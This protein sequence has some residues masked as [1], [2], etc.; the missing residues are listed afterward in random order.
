M[1]LFHYRKSKIWWFDF[2]FSGRRIRES[3]KT[4]NT[5]LARDAERAKRRELEEEYNGVPKRQAPKSLATAAEEY[6]ELKKA[7]V[8]PNTSLIMTQ[9]F[10]LHLLPKLGKKL[11]TEIEPGTWNAYTEYRLGQGAAAA[12]VNHELGLVRGILRRHRL[13]EAIRQ[14]VR[15]LPV[16][17]AHGY[18]LT[19]DEESLLLQKCL[20]STFPYI[21]PIVVMALSTGMRREEIQLL[22]WSNLNFDRKTV[23]VGKSKT[24]NGTGRVIHLNVRAFEVV[25]A[26][27]ANFPG[28]RPDHLLFPGLG[29]R[30]VRWTFSSGIPTSPLDF[31]YAWQRVRKAAGLNCRFHDLRHTACTRMLDANIPFS[32]VGKIMGWSASTMVLM[33]RRYGHIGE[34]AHLRAVAVLDGPVVVPTRQ[35]QCEVDPKQR[36]Q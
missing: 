3:T 24:S 4:T 16:N 17:E 21:Y 23:T 35:L 27:A 5:A 2:Q 11:L 10:R 36:V 19:T 9:C 8:T 6:V 30:G 22:H 32:N 26:W 33:I 7:R 20:D 34:E 25:K 12:T 15:L 31:R 28:R 29:K 13:W 14:D 1:S 18:A